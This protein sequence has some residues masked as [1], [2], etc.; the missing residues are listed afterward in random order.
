MDKKIRAIGA[1][2]LVTVWAALTAMAWFHPAQEM[3]EAE[4]RPLAQFPQL[5]GE[6][7]LSGKFATGFEDYAVDQFPGRDTFRTLKSLVHN[8]VMQQKDNNGIYIADGYAVK[9]EYPLQPDSI[10]HATKRFNRVYEKYLQ[11][12]DSRIYAAVIPDKGYYLAEDNGYLAPDYEKL[13]A[14]VQQQMPWATYVDITDCLTAEDYYFT[15]THWKQ[16]NLLLAAQ[17]LASGMGVSISTEYETK[18]V[19]ED[20]YGVYYGQLA[21]PVK[22]DKIKYLTNS[23]LESC[24]VTNFDTGM[25]VVS[26][27]YDL[28][29]STSKDPYELFLCGN[30][31]LVTIENPNALTSKELIVFRDSFGSSLVPLLATGYSKVTL[32]DI[33]YINS[34]M[35]GGFIKF[36]DQDV[37]F[38]YSTLVLNSSTS[39]K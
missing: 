5:N 38:L 2:I 22:P 29:K 17:T 35:L 6:S 18:E 39:F 15:D 30:S 31:A 21:L 34:G 16:E 14:Q 33:R 25:P 19:P 20:F 37:L 27:M 1:V 9:L 4:R 8:Y 10:Q 11:D 12:T 32:V 13:F 36:K 7:L 3:S 26:P 28:S 23:I 24:V